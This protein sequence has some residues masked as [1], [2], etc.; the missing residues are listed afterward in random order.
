MTSLPHEAGDVRQTDPNRCKRCGHPRDEHWPNH[1]RN[2]TACVTCIDLD[3]H[4]RS[5]LIDYASGVHKPGNYGYC[6]NCWDWPEE[7][8]D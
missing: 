4:S 6:C 1:G 2:L 3:I 8:G 7:A 5:P